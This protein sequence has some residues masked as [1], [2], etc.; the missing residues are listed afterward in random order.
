MR[1]RVQVMNIYEYLWAMIVIGSSF[2]IPERAELS[3]VREEVKDGA[4]H[5][6]FFNL[7]MRSIGVSYPKFNSIPDIIEVHL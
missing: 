2:D 5:A 3:F 7:C 6:G 4:A 1:S